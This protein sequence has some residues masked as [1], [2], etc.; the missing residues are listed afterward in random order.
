[1]N[2]LNQI[3][4]TK[5]DPPPPKPSVSFLGVKTKVGLKPVF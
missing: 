1:M 3:L 5:C 2:L 4:F